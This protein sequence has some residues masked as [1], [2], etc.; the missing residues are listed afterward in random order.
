MTGIFENDHKQI[1]SSINEFHIKVTKKNSVDEKIMGEK[2][3]ITDLFWCFFGDFERFSESEDISDNG[4][5]NLI[6][7]TNITGRLTYDCEKKFDRNEIG[8]KINNEFE[9]FDKMKN[10]D[11]N[12][13]DG[14]HNNKNYNINDIDYNNNN[15]NKTNIS[16]EENITSYT[17]QN[18]KLKNNL[19]KPS[20][21]I[22]IN[23]NENTDF[24]LSIGNV[25]FYCPTDNKTQTYLL[26]FL[27]HTMMCFSLTKTEI[28]KKSDENFELFL[29]KLESI[30]EK[31]PC[32]TSFDL[33]TTSS[34]SSS[35]D[36]FSSFIDTQ[37]NIDFMNFDMHDK[38]TNDIENFNKYD[39]NDNIDNMNN[40]NININNS[41]NSN[42]VTN[43]NNNN[44]TSTILHIKKSFLF[45]I[46]IDNLQIRESKQNP[47]PIPS[48]V[49]LLVVEAV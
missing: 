24:K 14:N 38:N 37:E 34:S 20:N 13:I 7:V 18:I 33:H 4:Y 5:S 8:E 49:M 10:G 16:I 9:N 42:I 12:M 1:I 28:Q 44:N 29:N 32:S 15:D 25:T 17:T 31:L 3:G 27:S 40:D 47:S 11:D 35:F 36:S 26:S 19:N 46:I 30:D 41:Y 43:D 22:I 39:N 21:I 6:S 23:Q 48:P 45:N 2:I